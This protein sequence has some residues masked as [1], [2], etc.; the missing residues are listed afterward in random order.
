MGFLIEKHEINAYDDEGNTEP[1]AH[2]EGHT[3]FKS[4]LVFLQEFDEESEGENLGQT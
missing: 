4:H 2:V 1:L 3:F